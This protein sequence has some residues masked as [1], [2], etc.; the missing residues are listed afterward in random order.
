M[1]HVIVAAALAGWF[2]G[3]LGGGCA[4]I[5][6]VVTAQTRAIVSTSA[7][8]TENTMTPEDLIAILEEMRGRPI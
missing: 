3:I 4:A 1:R 5:A 7:P 8:L 2:A 6:I